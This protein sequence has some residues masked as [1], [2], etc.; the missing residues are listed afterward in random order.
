MFFSILCFSDYRG[1]LLYYVCLITGAP[2]LSFDILSDTLGEKREEFPLTCYGVSGSQSAKGQQN[3]VIVLK[4]SNLHRTTKPKSEEDEE[5][6]DSESDED[7]DKKPEL[8][9]ALI[10]HA[11]CINRIRVTFERNK[12]T[13]FTAFL[14]F[15]FNRYP[16]KKK[17]S[18]LTSIKEE[19]CFVALLM[20]AVK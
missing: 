2:C 17:N 5:E 15:S 18:Y 10:K 3:H 14:N 4:M 1:T 19:K 13:I 7:E 12:N 20:N 6:S 9:T 11:G 16:G 8:E